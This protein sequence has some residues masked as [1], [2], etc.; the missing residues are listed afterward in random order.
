MGDIDPR[1]SGL[2]S[3]S[4]SLNIVN[5]ADTNFALAY[6]QSYNE[7]A[8]SGLRCGYQIDLFLVYIIV[9]MSPQL[10]HNFM[11]NRIQSWRQFKYK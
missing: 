8:S 1:P 9:K 11:Y 4:S 3:S 6:R 10:S 2:M 5:I 7:A